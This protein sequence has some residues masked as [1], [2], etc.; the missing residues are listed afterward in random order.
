MILEPESIN[1][2]LSKSAFPKSS[3]CNPPEFWSSEC[4]DLLK[5]VVHH[6]DDTVV[7][8]KKTQVIIDQLIAAVPQAHKGKQSSAFDFM[9]SLCSSLQAC[10]TVGTVLKHGEPWQC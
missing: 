7:T 9:L 10:L 1:Y 3:S 4:G 5:H 2:W 6:L 8:A